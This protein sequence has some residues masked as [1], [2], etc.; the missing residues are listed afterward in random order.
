MKLLSFIFFS[1]LVCGCGKEKEQEPQP[2]PAAKLF[3]KSFDDRWEAANKIKDVASRQ[4][5][6]SKL[7]TDGAEVQS[8][9]NVTDV[10]KRM[11]NLENGGDPLDIVPAL[12]A[13]LRAPPGTTD[14][15]AEACALI[16]A[17]H[18]DLKTAN[19]LAEL[20]TA[21]EIRDRT[22]NAIAKGR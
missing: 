15:A 20:I 14:K 8:I 13:A 5:A 17:K 3:E 2:S 7:A 19:K 6:L 4:E 16:L 21:S 1:M 11:R 22:L 10:L 9:E 18:S 12:P